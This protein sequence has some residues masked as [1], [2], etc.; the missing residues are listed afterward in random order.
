[1]LLVLCGINLWC[2]IYII[3]KPVDNWIVFYNLD[4][5]SNAELYISSVYYVLT[6]LVTVGYGNI[7]PVNNLEFI[8]TIVF[9]FIGVAFF[10]YVMG[11]LT[12]TF[13]KLS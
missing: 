5:A 7:A 11:T 3:L 8:Y 10:S 12:F 9:E 2:K 4:A 1:M 13:A 6:I